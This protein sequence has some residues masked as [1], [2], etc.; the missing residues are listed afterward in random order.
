MQSQK[1]PYQQT[2]ETV[3][4][5][6]ERIIGR[7]DGLY[8]VVISDQDGAVYSRVMRQ[9]SPSYL[10]LYPVQLEMTDPTSPSRTMIVPATD[11]GSV[12]FATTIERGSKIGCGNIKTVTASL[13]R[14]YG[15]LFTVLTASHYICCSN[16]FKSCIVIYNYSRT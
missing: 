11:P 4:S 9:D 13:S 12:L 6:L 3:N 7:V 5:S 1:T 16:R 14:I 15:H 10:P 2:A 8:G